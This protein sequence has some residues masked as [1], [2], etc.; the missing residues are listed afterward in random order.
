MLNKVLIID[1]SLFDCTLI[2]K[3]VR[4][5]SPA[6]NVARFYSARN[7]LAYLH[8]LS[9]DPDEF[10]DMILLDI[11]M[12]IM[13]GFEF[14][15]QYVTLPGEL[16]DRCIVIMISSTF[17]IEDSERMSKYPVVKRFVYKPISTQALKELHELYLIN[18]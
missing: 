3:V 11:N 14:L 15:D 1:D 2:E 6:T 4:N 18:Y 9:G 8:S 5:Y 13:D 7:A 16:L 12:P 17:K 10:P